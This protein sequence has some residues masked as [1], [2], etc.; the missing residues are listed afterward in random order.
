[1]KKNKTPQNWTDFNNALA[2]LAKTVNDLEEE[3][4]QLKQALE[5]KERER[6]ELWEQQGKT[7]TEYS[8]RILQ[9]ENQVLLCKSLVNIPDTLTDCVKELV[10]ER[11]KGWDWARTEGDYDL[12]WLEREE[13]PFYDSRLQAAFD[14]PLKGRGRKKA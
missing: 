3:N 7:E 14:K 9:L 1:M 2:Q 12:R 4:R 6:L 10:K 11:L 5:D 8:D 13:A